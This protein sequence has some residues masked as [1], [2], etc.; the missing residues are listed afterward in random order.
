MLSTVSP[1]AHRSSLEEMLDSLRRRDEIPNDIPPALPVR[2]PSKGRLPSLVRARRSLPINCKISS[3]KEPSGRK[4]SRS[5][6]SSAAKREPSGAN[7]V[8][9]RKNSSG[10]KTRPV[11]KKPDRMVG[12]H[13]HVVENEKRL[14]GFGS[15]KGS[16]VNLV[17]L[18]GVE[19]PYVK[20]IE[21]EIG[22]E[23]LNM[24]GHG[25]DSKGDLASPSPGNEY[26]WN[27]GY[28]VKKVRFCFSSVP[29]TLHVVYIHFMRVCLLYK[30]SAYKT[31]ATCM[32]VIVGVFH[33]KLFQLTRTK[34]INTKQDAL[35]FT[36]LSKQKK[37]LVS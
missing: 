34:T 6:S 18:P 37:L 22:G 16:N 2:P 28:A 14:V 27:A 30:N 12:M 29:Y 1:S 20:P 25:S 7:S 24:S 10:A 23:R 31:L 19:S 13:V 3:P 9:M 17:E 15:R 4:D 32:Y 11:L 21:R 33:I 26:E 8:P 36:R 35:T 5:K